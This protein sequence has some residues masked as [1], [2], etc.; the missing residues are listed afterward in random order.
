MA[1]QR[2]GGARVV[3]VVGRGGKWVGWCGGESSIG[4]SLSALGLCVDVPI[5]K[6]K[7]RKRVGDQGG[8]GRIQ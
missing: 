4:V 6:E 1:F 7:G 8:G 2:C 5:S 3:G